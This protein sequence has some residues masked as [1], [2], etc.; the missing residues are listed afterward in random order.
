MMSVMK[1]TPLSSLVGES[2]GGDAMPPV[3]HLHQ[4]NVTPKEAI[5]IQQRLRSKVVV[6]ALVEE[7]HL[8][9]G[10]DVSFDK[11]SDLVYAGVVV[12]KL[13]EFIEVGE[14]TAITRVKFPYIPGLLS[15]RESPPLLEA[16]EKLSVKPDLVMIDGQGYAHPR[17]FG[18]ASHFGLLVDLPTIGCAKTLLI[19]RFEEPEPKAGSSSPLM[20]GEEVIG[21]ALRTQDSVNPVFVSIGHRINLQSAIEIVMRCTSDYRIPEPTRR[22]HLLVNALRR[23]EIPK[24]SR[25]GRQESLF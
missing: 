17:R 11:G 19:G 24:T 6:A 12:L 21:A 18:I 23:G 3:Q 13:P 8:V 14:S 9:A 5:D 22:A 4:W 25:A 1:S 10:C 20:D 7:A 2:V 16:W 15:F